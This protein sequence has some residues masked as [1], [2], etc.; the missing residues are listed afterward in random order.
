MS[1]IEEPSQGVARIGTS[2]WKYAEWRGKFYPKG[3]VQRLELSYA[4]QKMRT[5]ELNG[6]FYGLMRPSTYQGWASEV[7]DDFQFAVKGW[8]AV[9]HLKRLNNVTEP[10]S[11]FFG[12]GVLE[13]GAKLGPILWQLPPSLKFEAEILTGFLASLPRTISDAAGFAG[14]N[15]PGISLPI[16]Y[17]LEPRNESFNDPRVEEL[18][19]HYDVALVTSDNP[20]RFPVFHRVTASFA[21][22]RLHGVPKMYY[23]DYSDVDLGSW[24]ERIRELIGSGTDVYC[25]FDNTALAHAPE[26]AVSLERMIA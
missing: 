22:L 25:Y 21:Y 14:A 2:G 24:A 12:S 7:S 11:E 4:A 26:N 10:L 17:A 9:T 6:P 5:L 8:K 23:S 16:R 19:R 18:L 3:L 13:L 1:E 20:G 15:D